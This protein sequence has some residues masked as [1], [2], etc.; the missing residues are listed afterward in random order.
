MSWPKGYPG[1]HLKSLPINLNFS[2]CLFLVLIPFSSHVPL[3]TEDIHLMSTYRSQYC[4]I[5]TVSTLLVLLLCLQCSS[6]PCNVFFTG[7]RFSVL[8]TSVYDVVIR[9]QLVLLMKRSIIQ[10]FQLL[11]FHVKFYFFASICLHN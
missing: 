9:K 5:I 6:S 1:N 10:R 4:S 3:H 2:I 11:V 8:W 7:V